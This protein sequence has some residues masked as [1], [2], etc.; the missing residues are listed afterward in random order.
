MYSKFYYM[1]TELEGTK[2]FENKEEYCDMRV[3]LAEN[4]SLDKVTDLFLSLFLARVKK[5]ERQAIDIQ[6]DKDLSVLRGEPEYILHAHARLGGCL[7]I[8]AYLYVTEEDFP[9][10]ECDE[11]PDN[12][13]E[14]RKPD[15]IS[16]FSK[17]DVIHHGDVYPSDRKEYE[18]KVENF[19]KGKY[20]GEGRGHITML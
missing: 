19:L 1:F 13:E 14:F 6:L 17:W 9:L 12:V 15:S 18:E 11:F 5:T 20:I 10:E 8:A 3:F 16:D 4:C 2:T 7:G